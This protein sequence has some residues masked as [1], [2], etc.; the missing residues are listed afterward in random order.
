MSRV[1]TRGGRRRQKA[2]LEAL[3]TNN[4]AVAIELIE[5]GADVHARD[6][7]HSSALHL[8]VDLRSPCSDA[9][10]RHIVRALIERGA[11][12]DARAADGETPLMRAVVGEADELVIRMLLQNG[13]DVGAKNARNETAF[14]LAVLR[15]RVLAVR[16]LIEYDA[17]ID[18]AVSV[19]GGTAL[20]LKVQRNSSPPLLQLLLDHGADTNCRDATGAS[21]VWHAATD[22]RRDLIRALVDRG[23]DCNAANDMGE[24]P[25]FVAIRLAQPL[26]IRELVDQGAAVG[27]IHEISGETP[28][29]YAARLG[30]Y[31]AIEALVD[32]GANPNAANRWG[33]TP[34]M[35]AAHCHLAVSS[36]L[37]LG[38]DPLAVSAH[39]DTAL[40]VAWRGG[41]EFTVRTLMKHG[42]TDRGKAYRV[43][44]VSEQTA[45]INLSAADIGQDATRLGAMLN[46]PYMSDFIF[47]Y[48]DLPDLR[49]LTFTNRACLRAVRKYWDDPTRRRALIEE[50]MMRV[51]APE[52][53]RERV[54]IRCAMEASGGQWLWASEHQSHPGRWFARGS[55]FGTYLPRLLGR[56]HRGG[57]DD[58]CECGVHS[59]TQPRFVLLDPEARQ[60]LLVCASDGS[61]YDSGDI[62]GLEMLVCCKCNAQ[63]PGYVGRYWSACR[64]CLSTR[65]LLWA[66]W[67][68]EHERYMLCNEWC[69]VDA[70]LGRDDA[71]LLA[72]SVL[73]SLQDERYAG[74]D[75]S[76]SRCCQLAN[77]REL[78]SAV[79][80]ALDLGDGTRQTCQAMLRSPQ[81]LTIVNYPCPVT[82]HGDSGARFVFIAL[83]PNT[84]S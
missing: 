15:D 8:A 73:G 61:G 63:T 35:L 47:A 24:T 38:A 3:G 37:S 84:G 31:P 82:R 40:G 83:L 28:L 49:A 52:L 1:T 22:D 30:N 77:T 54:L 25:L 56:V 10:R 48:L 23:A 75:I 44:E 74:E 67:F 11:D 45:Y 72:R 5:Q 29:T 39:G 16:L 65:P 81:S 7:R 78:P 64:A 41:Y 36:L 4:A 70:C 43:V 2:L 20:H 51:L 59:P 13:A 6:A 27:A 14:A 32:R 60:P 17:D 62:T 71:E 9:R 12:V 46:S 42:A 68:R 66:R 57:I 69:D 33:E 53:V 19:G 34:L 26:A 21:P 76:F 80:D 58:D 79:F 18:Q 50:A 55:S